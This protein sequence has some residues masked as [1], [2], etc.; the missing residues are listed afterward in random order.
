MNSIHMSKHGKYVCIYVAFHLN[1]F[2]KTILYSPH[3]IMQV[4]SYCWYQ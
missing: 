4:K 2:N 3:T 1:V